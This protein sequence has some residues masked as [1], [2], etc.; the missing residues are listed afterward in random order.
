MPELLLH[1][2]SDC[3]V[4]ERFSANAKLEADGS[5]ALTYIIEG[6]VAQ[7][8]LPQPA[9]AQQTDNLWQHTC[10]ELFARRADEEGY[11][12]FNFSPSTAFAAYSFTGYREGMKP[13]EM[14]ALPSVDT[15]AE[16]NTL[17]ISAR[18]AAGALPHH[19]LAALTAVIELKDG[20]KS[21]WSLRHA[22]GKPDFHNKEG[23]VLPLLRAD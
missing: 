1:P 23:F 22:A 10:F 19:A 2:G 21:Y 20:S 8:A 18:I 5:L 6:D 15:Y 3:P 13:L 7:I 11:R 4:I 16:G 12:E 17:T 9:P 14:A